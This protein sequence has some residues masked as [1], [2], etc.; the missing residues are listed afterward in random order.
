MVHS[1]MLLAV[2]VEDHHPLAQQ[3]IH[4]VLNHHMDQSPSMM[5]WSSPATIVS[6]TQLST[7]RYELVV[8]RCGESTHSSILGYCMHV[9]FLHHMHM[10]LG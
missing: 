6:T 2:D 3:H 9:V 5:E 10:L 1:H 7:C 4:V 8:V